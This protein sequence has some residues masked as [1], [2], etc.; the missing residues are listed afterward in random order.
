MQGEIPAI[1]DYPAAGII[2]EPEVPSAN[3]SQIEISRLIVSV[4]SAKYYTLIGTTMNATNIHYGNVFSRFNTKWD[5]YQELKKNGVQ[6]VQLINYKGNDIKVIKWVSTFTD[7]LSQNYGSRGT[8]VYV[9]Q[10][11]C[12]VT[13]ELDDPFDANLY[14]GKMV[15][16]MKNWQPDFPKMY[17]ST[18]ITTHQYT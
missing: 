15:V 6:N 17:Q 4:Q 14:H 8:L 1:T 3:I 2:V 16:F 5:T 13:S 12:A 10:E 11:S 18:I 7:C 9:L